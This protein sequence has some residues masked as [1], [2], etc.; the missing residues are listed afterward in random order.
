MFSLH[1]LLENV[2]HHFP[3]QSLSFLSFLLH[4]SHLVRAA[5]MQVLF[6]PGDV[7]EG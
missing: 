6:S 3:L 7:P 1:P 5:Q 2:L 4:P